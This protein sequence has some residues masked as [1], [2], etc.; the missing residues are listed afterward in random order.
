MWWPEA[1][2][3]IFST[4]YISPARQDTCRVVTYSLDH[5]SL[6]R[7]S[8]QNLTRLLGRATVRPVRTSFV[9]QPRLNIDV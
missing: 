5:L 8:A 2:T 4:M 1:R 3:A 9:V 6:E 7:I